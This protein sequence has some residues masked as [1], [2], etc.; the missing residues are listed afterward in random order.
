METKNLKQS[1]LEK[2]R[3][4]FF[5]IGLLISSSLAL[6]AFEYRS[7]EYVSEVPLDHDDEVIDIEEYNR[8][9]RIEKPKPKEEQQQQK[10]VQKKISDQ[11]KIV[12]EE[13]L[14]DTLF[15]DMPDEDDE[16]FE[17]VFGGGDDDDDEPME[18]DIVIFTPVEQMPEY[19]HGGEQGLFSYLGKSIKYPQMAKEAGIQGT[20]Y[21]SFTV[22][23]KGNVSDIKVLRG[24]GGGC[25]EEAVR[26]IKGM[27]WH[28]GMQR[29]KP[30]SVNFTLPIKFVL[31]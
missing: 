23:K 3:P 31:Q 8:I 17:L 6:M 25:D 4:L 21:V 14:V 5:A 11:I 13:D 26:V 7:Y 15:V 9:I 12:D 18:E 30:V 20:V 2:R 1:R 27:C 29:N 19:C 22:R 28:P 10:K 16:P 24:I